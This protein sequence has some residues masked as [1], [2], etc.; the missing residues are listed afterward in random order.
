MTKRNPAQKE[1]I[2][3]QDEL[4]W[5][6]TRQ[7]V[8]LLREKGNLLPIDNVDVDVPNI[9]RKHF[10]CDGNRCVQWIGKKALVDR[11]CCSRYDVSVTTRDRK[12][13]MQNF[14]KIRE[15]LP[16]GHPF[17]DPNINPFERDDDYGWDL[18]QDKT[19]DVCQFTVYRDA[20]RLCAI[21]MTA[22]QY[23]ERPQDWKPIACSMWPLVIDDYQNDNGDDRIL[24]TIY[25]GDTES[26]FEGKDEDPFACIVD[27]NPEYPRLYQSEKTTLEFAF[28]K[29]WWEKLDK[30]AK[31]ILRCE[32]DE[33]SI[34]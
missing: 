19:R 12:L 17:R 9:V 21:H 28:G 33:S 2:E 11:S 23:G 3:W 30:A 14:N 29:E 16:V 22:M 20:M 32:M 15:N 34:P 7:Y 6:N 31:R 5:D 10:M 4:N 25:C 18:V 24:L 26:L 27:E 1:L 8:E 13:V